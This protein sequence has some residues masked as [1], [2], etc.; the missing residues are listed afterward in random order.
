MSPLL[1]IVIPV[2]NVENYVGEC[3]SSIVTQEFDRSLY[4]IVVINDG[5]QDNSMSIVKQYARDYPGIIVFEQD[6]KG[7][8][9]A[10][11]LGMQKAHGVF[12]WF[13]DSDD[14]LL[15]NAIKKII[16]IISDAS[17]IDVIA[18]PLLWRYSN[19]ESDHVDYTIPES[20]I[21]GG[22]DLIKEKK[23]P[24][25][26][27]PRF[28]IRRHLFY[29]KDVFFPAGIT[30]EDEY[31]GRVLL[32]K[33]NRVL[34]QDKPIYVYRQREGS[35]MK[36]DSS[37]SAKNLVDI[38]M[39]LSNYAARVEPEDKSWFKKDIL[40]LLLETYTRNLRIVGTDD[41]LRFRQ[42]YSGFILK[43]FS[44]FRH[45]FSCKDRFLGELLLKYPNL[46]SK[47]VLRIVAYKHQRKEVL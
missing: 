46:Y 9:A 47:I 26:A 22:K 23:I 38:Y 44:A 8:S 35:I 18:F 11:S 10:R 27:T 20:Q 5:T 43:E 4:E 16:S 25:W 3:L 6:N 31:F 40:C 36:R 12:V 2:Y 29:F 21:C 39:L 17:D 45:L 32:Y 13:V 37:V 7:L 42:Q 15:P 28:V 24:V 14:Y 33:A 41:F 30:H 34:I 19:G 1:S